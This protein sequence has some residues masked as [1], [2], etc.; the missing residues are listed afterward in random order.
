MGGEER[1]DGLI[2]FEDGVRMGLVYDGAY[3]AVHRPISAFSMNWDGGE[4]DTVTLITHFTQRKT[5]V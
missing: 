5:A 3:E 1:Q 4:E 2:R